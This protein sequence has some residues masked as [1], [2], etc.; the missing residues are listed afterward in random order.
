ML[1]NLNILMKYF[2]LYPIAY[3]FLII[4]CSKEKDITEKK[5]KS[6]AVSVENVQTSNTNNTISI[7]GN[8]DGS[9]TVK[10]GF[11]VA[12]RINSIPFEEGRAVKNGQVV[13]SL[14][15]V[16]YQIADNVAQIQLNQANDELQR[17]KIMHDRNSLSDADYKKVNFVQQQAVQQTKLNRHNLSETRIYAPFNGVVIR[18]LA[19]KGEIVGVGTPV[20]VISD[21]NTVYVNAYIPDSELRYVKIGQQ[22]EVYVSSIDR[23]VS[24]TV[25]EVSSAADPATRTFTVKIKVPN[26][27]WLIRPGMIA[28]VKIVY[29]SSK[30]GIYLP[31]DA[32]LKNDNGQYYVYIVD[33]QKLKAYKRVI[34]IGEISQNKIEVVSGLNIGETIVSKGQNKLSEGS[35]VSIKN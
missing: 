13:A 19:E 7:S 14:D 10:V 28:E 32:I 5:N 4:S 27:N 3:L 2:F 23:T 34:S 8:V 16:S 31:S 11:L 15:P 25:T 35:S 30:R 24:G 33:K 17:L 18:K 22:S 26:P 21:I 12:G 20:M 6:I 29:P 1:K 9:K